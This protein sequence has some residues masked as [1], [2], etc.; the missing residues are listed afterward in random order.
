VRLPEGSYSILTDTG[1]GNVRLG[2]GIADEPNGTNR[3]RINSGT[4]DVTIERSDV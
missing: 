1:I 2:F 4:G 3:I